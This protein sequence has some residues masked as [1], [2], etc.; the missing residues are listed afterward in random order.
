MKEVIISILLFFIATISFEQSFSKLD[1]L[2]VKNFPENSR[3]DGKWVYYSGNN[4]IKRI[5]KPEV[6]KTLTDFSFYQ[7]D[8]TNYLGYHVHSSTCLILFDSVNLKVLLAVPMWYSDMSTDFVK[9]FIGKKFSDTAS[10]M[11]FIKELQELMLIGSLGKF[12]EPRL[13]NNKVT[14]DMTNNYSKGKDVW[15]HIEIVIINNTI[16]KFKS[17]NPTTKESVIAQ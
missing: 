13:D 15:R 8:M 6:N 11:N 2:L 9:L 5:I 17:T 7:V 14:F 10:L 3:T 4:A 16:K 1:S 12:S